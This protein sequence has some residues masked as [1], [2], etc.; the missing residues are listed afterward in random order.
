MP[1]FGKFLNG[2]PTA[3]RQRLRALLAQL[4]FTIRRR[5]A[6]G[7]AN[8]SVKGHVEDSKL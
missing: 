8:T 4:D 6:D 7:R 5:F 3:V 2:S 1:A